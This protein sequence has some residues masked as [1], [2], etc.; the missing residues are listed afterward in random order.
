M[1][2]THK[3]KFDG[4]YYK[5]GEEVPNIEETP[6]GESIEALKAQAD[7]LGIKYHWNVGAEKLKTLI[8]EHEQKSGAQ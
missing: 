3:V 2:Y 4:K 7:T 8:E 6:S 1:K 5:P